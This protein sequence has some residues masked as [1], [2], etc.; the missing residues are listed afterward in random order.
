MSALE[1][2]LQIS[3]DARRYDRL[4]GEAER[5]GRSVAALVRE[6]IDRRFPDDQDQVRADAAH[7]LLDLERVG[8]DTSSA[9]GRGDG[10]AELKAAY[11]AEMDAKSGA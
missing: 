8:A 6:A 2:R 10:P 1:R 3:L 4:A 9:G 11:E 5:S 7:A